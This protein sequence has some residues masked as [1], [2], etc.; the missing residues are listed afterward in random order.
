MRYLRLLSHEVGRF[1]GNEKPAR[2]IKHDYGHSG[3]CQGT[4]EMFD[5]NSTNV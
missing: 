3:T 4:I 2:L 1:L 5:N